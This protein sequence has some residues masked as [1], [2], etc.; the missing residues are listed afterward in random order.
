MSDVELGNFDDIEE[1]E[2]VKFDEGI[3]RVRFTS[4]EFVVGK[5]AYGNKT[6]TFTGVEG[7]VDKLLGITSK[8]L[9]LKL[10]E[11]HPLEGKVMDIER[12]GEGME[13]DY[14]VTEVK[15]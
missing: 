5:N 12:V 7:T 9:M 15:K 13:T 10:K 4:S 1:V 8:R 6:W 11:F 14:N 3:P 2:Y